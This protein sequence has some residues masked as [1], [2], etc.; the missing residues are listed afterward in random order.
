[1]ADFTT[2]ARPYAKAAFEAALAAG[3]LEE[4]SRMLGLTAAVTGNEKVAAALASPSLTGPDQAKLVIDLCGDA[5]DDQLRNLIAILAENKRLAL[6]PDIVR[7]FEQMKA[8]HEKRIDV[9]VYSAFP[10]PEDAREKLTE[11]LKRRLQREVKI[12]SE[13]DKSLIGGVLIRAGDLVIDGSVRGRLN[14]LAEA[15]NS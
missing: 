7:L 10:L 4:W 5:I 9:D 11:A 12:H 3:K 1:M 6:L 2:F 14:K 13:V 15:M 8:V